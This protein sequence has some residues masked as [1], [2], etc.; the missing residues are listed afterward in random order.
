MKLLEKRKTRLSMAI[1]PRDDFSPEEG[2]KG[3]Y[4]IRLK[5]NG[6][7]PL[8]HRTGYFLFLDLP[9]GKHTIITESRFYITTGIE[10]DTNELN[11]KMPVTEMTLKPNSDYPFPPEATLIKGT[12]TDPEGNP[13][14]N[15]RVRVKK[16]DESTTTD[17]NGSFVLYFKG[18]Q[19]D[20]LKVKLFIEKE[21]FKKKRRTYTINKGKTKEVSITLKPK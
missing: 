10:I 20:K 5:G 21:G 1:L 3:D 11:P 2:I 17:K 9:E 7:H 19:G 4:E 16:R 15:A 6:R 12:I 18:I 13:V 8:K 14:S